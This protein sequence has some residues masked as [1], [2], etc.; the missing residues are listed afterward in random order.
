MNLNDLNQLPPCPSTRLAFEPVVD[1]AFRVEP[2]GQR[3]TGGET[4]LLRLPIGSSRDHLVA[5]RR[6]Y[7]ATFVEP[8]DDRLERR[9][10]VPRAVRR[11]FGDADAFGG[12]LHEVLTVAQ[13]CDQRNVKTT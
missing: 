3:V 12:R 13:R 4:A 9:Q 1:L 7:R 10:V 2:I 5:L 6:R 11:Q 8:A